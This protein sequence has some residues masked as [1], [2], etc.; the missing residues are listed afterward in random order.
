MGDEE[1]EEMRKGEMQLK[2]PGLE[3]GMSW[4]MVLTPP[5]LKGLMQ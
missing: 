1:N 5:K 3:V 4:L 2:A